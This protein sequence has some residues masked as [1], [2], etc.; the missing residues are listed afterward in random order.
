[1]KHTIV[2]LTALAI[3]SGAFAARTSG[4]TELVGTNSQ[5]IK[6]VYSPQPWQVCKV[7]VGSGL[8]YYVK[9]DKITDV[10][11]HQRCTFDKNESGKLQFSCV[12]EDGPKYSFSNTVYVLDSGHDGSCTYVCKTGCYDFVPQTLRQVPLLP[13]AA[14]PPPER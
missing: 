2:F 6:V 9:D 7:G 4:P 3:S 14:P 8:I 11:P 1:M 5:G 13:L 10:W 12:S